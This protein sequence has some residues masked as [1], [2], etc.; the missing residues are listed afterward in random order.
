[1]PNPNETSSSHSA[2]LNRGETYTITRSMGNIRTL[3][4]EV[5]Y[6]RDWNLIR[7]EPG[8]V[9]EYQGSANELDRPGDYLVE[10][11]CFK[12]SNMLLTRFQGLIGQM[13]I[14][15]MDSRH[16]PFLSPA[17]R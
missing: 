11:A 14:I 12:P 17:K 3:H 10:N 9:L 13:D 4:K 1:M 6:W 15:L 5:G 2:E 8:D 7:L 16:I